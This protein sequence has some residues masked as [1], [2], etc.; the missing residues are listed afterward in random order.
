[1]KIADCMSRDVS[2]VTPDQPIFE[3]AKMMLEIDAGALPVVV[4]DKVEGMITDRDIAVRAVAEQM[5]PDTAVRT[6]MSGEL[7]AAYEDE[8]ADDV[9]LRMSDLQIRRMPVLSRDQALLGMISLADLARSDDGSTA[10]E[11]LSGISEPG[12]DHSPSAEG[13]GGT[14]A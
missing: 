4:D 7:V 14:A 13:Q 1:M 5:G 3:A 2:V 10:E 9:A 11:A 12:G 6:I 8:D